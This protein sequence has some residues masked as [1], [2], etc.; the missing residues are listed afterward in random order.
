MFSSR[1]CNGIQCRLCP[2]NC[3][4]PDGARG[5]CRVRANYG[6]NL[7]SLVYGK[8]ASV[9]LDPI[10]KKPV[11]HLLPG[12]LVYSLATAGC[13]LYCRSCQ[14]WG[15]SQIYPEESDNKVFIPVKL[16]LFRDSSGNLRAKVE[17]KEVAF[18]S[19]ADII[20]CALNTK[21]RSVAYTYSEPVVFY[22]Y[23]LHT[24]KL[25]RR[26]GLKNVMIT[27]GYINQEP[28]K[29]I[30]KYMDVIKVDLKGFNAEYY[31]KYVGGELEVLKDVLKTLKE[32]GVFLEIV[33]LV[34]PTLNDSDEDIS[35]LIDW[36]KRNL[37]A[38]TPIFFS[39]FSPNYKLTN[40]PA[41]PVETLEKA[42]NQ[43]L[44]RGLKY[45]Y[46]G[47]VPGHQGENT[48][49]PKCHRILIRRYGY[50]VLFDLV[51]ANGGRCPY[52]GTRIPGLWK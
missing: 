47:N 8:P 28:L 39:R 22:E 43:A 48:Y 31:R 37:G 40:L 1:V 49:C 33:N 30:A 4:L 21:C 34:I 44:K 15:I 18:L 41:T 50:M 20:K 19:P 17:N 16:N 5:L 12:S 36:V 14:N 35:R 7:V 13:N 27:G 32:E 25:A 9:H 23:M 26:K 52:D 2:F 11:F 3:F 51:S 10:E 45:V 6:G 29:E 46:I 24:A 38:D 42:R